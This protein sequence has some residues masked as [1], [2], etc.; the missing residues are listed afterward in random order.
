MPSYPS[1]L[2]PTDAVKLRFRE[3][4]MSEGNNLKS[5][6]IVPYGIYQ[7]FTPNVG[8]DPNVLILNTDGTRNDSVAVCET[9]LAPPDVAN[10]NLTIRSTDQLQLDFT[11]HTVFPCWV[12]LR[13]AYSI[14]AHPFSGT[15]SAQFVTINDTTTTPYDD[16]NPLAIHHGDIKICRIT[17]LPLKTTTPSQTVF[18][19]IPTDRDDNGGYLVTQTQMTGSSGLFFKNAVSKQSTVGAFGTTSLSFVPVPDFDTSPLVFSTSAVGD[20]VCW[21][22]LTV[23]GGGGV[24]RL[25]TGLGI[26]VDGIDYPT[27]YVYSGNVGG[28]P[29]QPLFGCVHIP[30]LAVGAHTA[31]VVVRWLGSVW[32]VVVNSYADSPTSLV[33]MHKG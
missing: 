32:Q 25:N 15:T 13:P 16:S 23:G 21:A 3:P 31:E 20:I 17:A 7:G 2:M 14:V 1:F 29:D 24:Y 10:Y 5:S 22:F 30:S 27:T 8:A 33:I 11:G 28:K 9:Y 12:V 4:Y 6:G 18:T 19:I 26:R